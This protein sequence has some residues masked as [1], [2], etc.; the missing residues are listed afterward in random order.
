MGFWAAFFLTH[1]MGPQ[2][3]H[4]VSLSLFR[5]MMSRLSMRLKRPASLGALPT[6][7]ILGAMKC[8][9]TSLHAYLSL[10]PE[11]SMSTEKELAFFADGWNWKQGADWY[12]RQFDAQVTIRGEASP[13][14]TCYPQYDS[15]PER[16]HALLPDV[17]L[18]Y[19]V[20]DPID[21]LVSHYCHDVARGFEERPLEVALRERDSEY[22]ARSQYHRQIS[23]Y[24]AYYDAESILIIDQVDLRKNRRDTL[25]KTFAFIGADPDMWDPRF[26][27]EHHVTSQKRQ[28]SAFGK[29]L[30]RT[31]PMRAVALVPPRYRW[32]L[33]D[34]LYRPF[35][36]PLDRP[37]VDDALHAVISAQLAEDV[38]SWRTFTGRAW[39][40]WSL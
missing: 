7:V 39:S 15:I 4:F 20:R 25:K 26:E 31:W 23:R 5:P 33:E 9:T 29:R 30:A 24:L 12:R 22:I 28:R 17:D 11:V 36:I 19:L 14:Y 18:I 32:P 38:A 21:R 40:D 1:A 2:T 34:A 13:Q 16:M 8:G 27:E 3:A 35:S 6:F 10:H 37:R